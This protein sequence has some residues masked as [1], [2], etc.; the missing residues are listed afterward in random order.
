MAGRIIGAVLILLLGANARADDWPMFNHDPQRSC[1]TTDQVEGPYKVL[2]VRD[3]Y[4]STRTLFVRRKPYSPPLDPGPK[5]SEQIP[6]GVQAIVANG[7]LYIGTT[8]NRLYALDAATGQTKWRVR[9]GDGPGAILHSPAV[10]RGLVYVGSTDRHLYALNAETGRVVW[11]FASGQGG[12]WNSPLPLGGR[13]F[14]GSRDR[15]LYALDAETG[16]LLWKARTGGPVLSSPSSDG[17][18]IY[19]ASEDLR[20]YCL[21][22]DSGKLAWRSKRL[23]G[24]SARWYCPVVAKKAGLLFVTTSPAELAD[25][26]Y[27]AGDSL[28]GLHYK[29]TP[30]RPQQRNVNGWRQS[31]HPRPNLDEPFDARRYEKEQDAIVHFLKKSPTHRTLHVL[32]LATGREKLV[33]PVLYRVGCGA[34]PTPPAVAPDGRIYVLNRSYYS[35]LDLSSFCVFGGIGRLDPKTGRVELLNQAPGSPRPLWG[36]GIDLICDESA[37]I[38]VG[39]RCLYIA[40]SDNLG[41]MELPSRRTAN[42]WGMRDFPACIGPRTTPYSPTLKKAGHVMQQSITEWHGPGRGALTV[43]GNRLYWVTAGAVV[44]LE[45]SAKGGN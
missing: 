44:A 18:R 8:S 41:T 19:V 15:N 34:V 21:E 17:E 5:L 13:L 43:A 36:N 12:F 42:I 38:T 10:W 33:A 2:W 28:A 40:H 1:G 25:S 22:A 3:F 11:A 31:G 6:S 37:A 26:L 14:A 45:G 30:L 27:G 16:K 39:G 7:T 4:S 24:R 32:D 23:P 9:L 29:G 35:N 20:V